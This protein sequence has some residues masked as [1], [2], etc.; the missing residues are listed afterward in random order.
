MIQRY[1]SRLQKLDHV[2]LREKLKGA[3]RYRRIAGYFRSSL[4]ELIHEE[5]ASIDDVRIVCNADLDPR[6][7]GVARSV[8]QQ[9][10]ALKE[11]WNDRPPE[12]DSVL[13]RE[14]Y[15]KLH[16]LLVKGNLQVR[17]VGRTTAAF[18]HGKAGVIE[19][20][21]GTKTSFM[22]SINDT[23]EAW[24]ENYELLWEDDSPEAVAWV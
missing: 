12:A 14:R 3:K 15:R 20:K 1:S 4:F 7:I 9:A 5:L 13:G 16:S 8:Q 2:F 18:L 24:S 11:K 23:R 17:V 22:G 10:M 21:S 6:D 19:A